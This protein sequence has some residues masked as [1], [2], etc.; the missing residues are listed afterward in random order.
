MVSEAHTVS[1]TSIPSLSLEKIKDRSENIIAIMGGDCNYLSWLLQQG[2]NP[3]KIEELMS[4]YS[5]YFPAGQFFFEI[6]AQPYTDLPQL[7]KV[8]SCILSLSKN[9]SIPCVVDNNFHYVAPDDKDA[10][11][12][13]TCIKDGKQYY[14]HGRK[15]KEGAWH[16]MSEDEIVKVLEKNGY[17]SSMIEE[18]I[19]NNQKV[20]EMIDL[21]IPL[22]Q[23]LFPVYE[24]P[25]HISQIYETFQQMK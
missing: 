4:M 7:R 3:K 1:N 15:K 19:G 24:S 2:E 8:D 17:E 11:D 14:E 5:A 16:I 6:T 10:F 21:N 12:I 23:L 9:L 18:R 13:A 22:H 25:E 20:I